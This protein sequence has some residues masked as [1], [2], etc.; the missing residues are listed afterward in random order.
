MSTLV[1]IS[2]L[3]LLSITRAVRAVNDTKV[4]THIIKGDISVS[5]VFK[6]Q[7]VVLK[8]SLI[9]ASRQK[10]GGKE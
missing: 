3:H 4:T 9:V 5:V 10:Q 7:D 8:L 6:L 2:F 1:R